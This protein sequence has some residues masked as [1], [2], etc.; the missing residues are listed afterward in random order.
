VRQ[1]GIFHALGSD[2]P[3]AQARIEMFKQS[4]QQLGWMVGH[5]RIGATAHVNGGGVQKPAFARF[6][7]SHNFRLFNSI[8]PKQP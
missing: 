6:L 3:E 5:R 2:D 8:D 7:A 4:L 1:I